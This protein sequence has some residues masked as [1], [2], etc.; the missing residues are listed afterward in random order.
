MP[1]Q[2]D[3]D[4]CFTQHTDLVVEIFGCT[5]V[6]YETING[7]GGWG[8]ETSNDIVRGRRTMHVEG[9]SRL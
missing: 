1:K 2:M 3:N 9:M 7:S 8:V 4:Q 5:K 6:K